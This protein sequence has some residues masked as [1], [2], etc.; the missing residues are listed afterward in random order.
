MN[1][2][3]NESGNMTFTKTVADAQLTYGDTATMTWECEKFSELIEGTETFKFT[4]DV[5]SVTG[6][7]SGINI[8]KKNYTFTITSPLIY[9]NGCFH[10]I[11]GAIEFEVLNEETK[12]IDYGIG[13]CDNKATITVGDLTEEIEL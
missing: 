7:G 13:E 4:D 11:S 1:T 10:P 9:K 6:D 3:K 12:V 2:G 8:D 5:W